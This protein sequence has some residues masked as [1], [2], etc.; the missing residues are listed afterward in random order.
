MSFQDVVL[1]IKVMAWRDNALIE[2]SDQLE[3]T[4][5]L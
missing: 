1:Q 5:L 3:K 2:A 4:F